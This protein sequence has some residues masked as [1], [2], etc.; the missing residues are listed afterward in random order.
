MIVRRYRKY[1]KPVIQSPRV[2]VVEDSLIAQRAIQEML[3]Q[4][5]CVV[6]MA[7]NGQLALQMLKKQYDFILLDIGLPDINGARLCEIIRYRFQ[8]LKTPIVA[9]T[10]PNNVSELIETRAYFN[11]FV[12][13]PLSLEQLNNVLIKWVPHYKKM[14]HK[15]TAREMECLYL[16]AQ[17]FSS[18]E[19]A[20]LL[21]VKTYTIERHRK[22]AKKKL[23]CHSLAHAVFKIM[24][25]NYIEPFQKNYDPNT[26]ERKK[27]QVS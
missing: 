6:E 26:L 27:G 18:K 2:L 13:K 19:S 15:L 3:K 1:D 11:D 9:Y 12:M 10:T 17:G 23:L 8:D 24:L 20:H 5:G 4:L 21:H 22:N 7:Q 25:C 16:A 14:K